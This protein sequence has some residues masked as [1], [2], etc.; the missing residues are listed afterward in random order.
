MNAGAFYRPVRSSGPKF[1][2]SARA[3]NSHLLAELADTEFF[4][5]AVQSLPRRLRQPPCCARRRRSSCTL[6]ALIQ[7]A[8]AIGKSDRYSSGVNCARSRRRPDGAQQRAA[9]RFGPQQSSQR[10][11][12]RQRTRH[13]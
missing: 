3:D 12:P 9:S 5:I 4:L 13:N 2:F 1:T 7:R 11:S 8:A 10:R 6:S